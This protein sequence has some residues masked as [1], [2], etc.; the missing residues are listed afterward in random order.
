MATQD[1]S[2]KRPMQPL[3]F[4]VPCPSNIHSPRLL[5]KFL[6][7]QKK[8]FHKSR[9]NS[10]VRYFSTIMKTEIECT[11]MLS[12]SQ[13]LNPSNSRS[14][15]QGIWLFCCERKRDVKCSTDADSINWNFV[16]PFNCTSARFL[17]DDD[18]PVTLFSQ[19]SCSSFFVPLKLPQENIPT[20]HL[21]LLYVTIV[22]VAS[23]FISVINTLLSA[24]SNPDWWRSVTIVPLSEANNSAG[25]TKL[26]NHSALKSS[27]FK[28]TVCSV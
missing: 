11:D 23:A 6:R 7:E 20:A 18:K 12:V 22:S 1:I 4:A 27:G 8:H 14:R 17:Q 21:H 15:R 19:K 24:S 16:H 10:H 28:S 2:Q 5:L 3:V 26:S 13:L 9:D 25:L